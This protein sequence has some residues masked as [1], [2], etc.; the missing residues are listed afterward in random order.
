[1]IESRFAR[2]LKQEYEC[3]E[4]EMEELRQAFIDDD[5]VDLLWKEFSRYHREDF[6][7]LV[8][9]QIKGFMK[10]GMDKR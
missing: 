1:M 6:R 8:I 2:W 7:A 5:F 9:E 3:G 10:H 4:F